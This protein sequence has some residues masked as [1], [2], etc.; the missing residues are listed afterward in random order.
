[1]MVM[2]VMMVIAARVIA[3]IVVAAEIAVMVVMVMMII[4]DLLHRARHGARLVIALQ[5]GDSVRDR[6]EKLGV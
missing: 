6:L 3:A 5:H 1:M 4:S 2:M